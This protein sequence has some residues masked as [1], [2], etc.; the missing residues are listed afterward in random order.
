MKT[1]GIF[2]ISG[3][4]MNGVMAERVPFVNTIS[5]PILS[6]SVTCSA[7]NAIVA[8]YIAEKPRP[9]GGRDMGGQ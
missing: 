5:V 3:P 1:N 6:V 9:Y 2:S 7:V 4:K 8:E